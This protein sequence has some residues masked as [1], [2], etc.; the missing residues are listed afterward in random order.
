VS[1]QRT[2][3]APVA[4]K[5]SS[6]AELTQLLR[7][8]AVGALIAAM[9]VYL[10]FNAGGFFPAAPAVVV[11]A[12]CLLTVL[13]VMLVSRP[14]EGFTPGLL[15]PLGLLTGFAIW[16]LA[17][18]LWSDATGR[19]LIEFDR[20][21]LYLLAFAFFGMLV[22]GKR[23][24][25]W[26]LR[27]F[28]V[29]AVAICAAGWVTRVAADVWPIS[30]DVMPERLSFP[31]TYWNAM[32]LLGALAIVA[33]VHLASSRREER[34][35]RALSAAATPLLASTLLLTYSRASLALVPIGILLYALI[36]RPR[37]LIAALGAI[38]LPVGVALAATYR[39][40]KVSS[41]HFA[42]PAAIGQGHKLALIVVLC[43]LV[44]GGLRALM[45][46]EIDRRLEHWIPPVFEPR[47]LW[48]A[49]LGGVAL[50]LVVAVAAGAP[51]WIGSQYDQFVHGD[52][53]GHHE[54][55]RARLTSA[56]NNGR[57][58]QWEVA[59]KA[60]EAEPLHGE[61]AGTYQLAWARHRPYR[62]TVIDAHSLYVEVLGEL[63][64][65]GFLLIGGTLVAIAIGLARRL[66]G[67]E[68]QVYAAVLVLGL[69]WAAHAG[70]DWDWEMPAV[71]A[72]LFALAGLGL[73]KPVD[74]RPAPGMASFEPAR[75][76]RLLAAVCVGVLAVTPAAIAISQSRL[77]AA[78]TA[79]EKGDCGTTI[80]DAL[81]SLETLKVRPDPYELIGYC[82]IRL[83]QSGLAVAQMEN[84]VD[85]D[86]E[87]WEPHFGLA[88][89]LA[90]AGRDPMPELYASRERN[91]RETQILEAIA[92]MRDET[93]REREGRA[94]ETR[95]PL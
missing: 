64:V 32:G 40:D 17:S 7:G 49:A 63:G 41:S 54:D 22:P 59:L 52:D 56:G 78:V 55:P 33:C 57:I 77:D 53:V 92:A 23:R 20:V 81:A 3:R 73:A 45:T 89:A 21:L 12:L 58:P 24:L 34:W 83:G 69:V 84:A 10:G 2:Y 35:V 27:G 87:S 28:V 38:V 5:P 50:L 1:Y 93:P 11:I 39:A 8:P 14:F 60:F 61:G 15:V 43:M 79:Y 62:F 88:M 65:V 16:V 66:R 71:T 85:R 95:P 42:S 26:G 47:T 90:A 9:T 86:P 75:I 72:W 31:L 94:I 51:H 30:A 13:G 67:E 76:V 82:D 4:V 70:V 37:R 25:E 19:A 36:A 44:A 91:P 46:I 74:D 68:R 18:A 6:G 80:N 48:A 29:A